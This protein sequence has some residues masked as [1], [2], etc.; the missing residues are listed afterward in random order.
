M[1]TI[2]DNNYELWLL[3][4][5][6]GELTE[7]EHNAVEQWLEVHPDAK[8]MLAL[9][10]EA[11][12]LEADEDVHYIGAVPG[13]SQM[14]WS[15]VLRWSAAA[16]VLAAMILPLALHQ[17]EEAMPVEVAKVQPV[18]ALTNTEEAPAATPSVNVA[19]TVAAI[20]VSAAEV[21][22]EV[23]VMA[24]D[25]DAENSEIAKLEAAETLLPAVTYVD[26]LIAYEEEEL[27][28]YDD[29]LIAY[30]EG[31]EREPG[32]RDLFLAVNDASQPYLER[33]Y[34]GHLIGTIIKSNK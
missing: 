18:T 19:Q 22:P 11:P 26:N 20:P 4:Y 34:V 14:L 2:N 32:L 5:A 25:L 31:C 28:T 10:V 15:V 1:T 12:H 9:Y 21:E 33:S 24:Q 30:D 17:R 16:A 23:Y 3:R 13:K 8:E 6:E 27:P 29:G 7:A